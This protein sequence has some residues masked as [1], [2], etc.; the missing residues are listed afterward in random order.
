MD[1]SVNQL[2]SSRRESPVSGLRR[3]LQKIQIA[4]SCLYLVL[5]LS[6]WLTLQWADLWWP[7]TL[8]MFSPRWVLALPLAILFPIAILLRSRSVVLLALTGVIVCWPVMG[9]SI[10][11][12]RLM[13]RTSTG[14][15]LRVMTL[16]MH[17]S[18]ADPK[19][20]EDLINN[21][22]LDIVAIQEWNGH[23]RAA[24]RSASGWHV[25]STPK[26]FLAS[27]Y[28]IK[29]TAELGGES[30]GEHA[31]VTHYVLDTTVGVIHVFNLHLATSRESINETIHENPEGATALR[32]NSELRL[33]QS[34][35]VAGKAA[36]C[37]GPL[38]IVGDFN[39]P[40][41]STIFAE[42]WSGYK[43]AFKSAGWGWGYTF[44]GAKTTVR[45]DHILA[46]KGLACVKCR[47]G[48][49]VGS[50]HRPVIAEL[51]WTGD[52]GKE[53]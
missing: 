40:P 49:N 51:V 39:T 34:A 24:L 8:L 7:A 16:N 36:E 37:Q 20:L 18:K 52:D 26:L 12:Q 22:E 14:K 30:S 50:P 31:S 32:A 43:D 4:I 17:Y 35:Y 13:N 47:V 48:P 21:A 41:E 3:N 45:I 28:P 9:L 44:I 11:W 6:A 53:G 15:S 29:K 19:L 27:R 23:D 10:P 46:R 5:V 1:N 2:N 42:V 25:H 38:L 33:K